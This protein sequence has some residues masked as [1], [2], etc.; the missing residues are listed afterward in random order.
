MNSLRRLAQHPETPKHEAEAA[1]IRLEDL[2]SRYITDSFSHQEEVSDTCQR[3]E[4]RFEYEYNWEQS[5]QS[6]SLDK[7]FDEFIRG[8]HAIWGRFMNRDDRE[9]AR[10]YVAWDVS[11]EIDALIDENNRIYFA[12]LIIDKHLRDIIVVNKKLLDQIARVLT[13]LVNATPSTAIL[14]ADGDFVVRPW[15]E[16]LTP[17]LRQRAEIDFPRL[18]ELAHMRVKMAEDELQRRARRIP[19]LAAFRRGV[20]A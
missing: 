15:F 1:R 16:S 10:R 11:P 18:Q 9:R 5:P 14:H 17:A 8:L 2:E 20:L 7:F 3:T 6:M 19:T 4:Y 13:Q 12:E